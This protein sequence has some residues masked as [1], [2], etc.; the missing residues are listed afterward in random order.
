MEVDH[1]LFLGGRSPDSPLDEIQ[2]NLL[3]V[4]RLDLN[5]F[6]VILLGQQNPGLD[7]RA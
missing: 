7:G 6:H 1:K 3:R 5:D 4:A 2:I